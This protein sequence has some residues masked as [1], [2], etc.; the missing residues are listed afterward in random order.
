MRISSNSLS[1]QVN[2]SLTTQLASAGQAMK[3]LSSGQQINKASDDSAAL[4]VSMRLMAEMNALDQGADNTQDGISMLQ[5]A[6][7]A[8]GETTELVQRAR[9]LSVQAGNGTLSDQDRAAI[10]EEFKSI[11]AEIDKISGGSEFNTKKLLDG[12]QTSVNIQTGAN[13]STTFSLPDVSTASLGLAGLD[14][15]NA[16]ASLKALD[17]ALETIA[18]NRSQIGATVNGL[19]HTYEAQQVASQNMA[20]SHSQ[21]R[22]AD[23]AKQASELAR[24][25]IMSQASLAMASQASQI[26]SGVLSL[27]Q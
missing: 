21:I 20:A 1:D 8:L 25:N 16:G 22:D 18:Q 24:S 7:G 10:N 5:T 3:R 17:S 15:G 13:Q 26:G 9:E 14:A 4:A 23:F 27:L 19:A 12:S 11:T 6:D 2:R